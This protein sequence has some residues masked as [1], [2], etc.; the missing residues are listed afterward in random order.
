MTIYARAVRGQGSDA[1]ITMR[2]HGVIFRWPWAFRDVRA[3]NLNMG[4][5][6]QGPHYLYVALLMDT[7]RRR[8]FSPKQFIR[9]GDFVAA[10]EW[11]PA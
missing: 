9:I 8:F 1:M 10:Y 5:W 6:K 4:E 3:F 11:M 2:E 7:E